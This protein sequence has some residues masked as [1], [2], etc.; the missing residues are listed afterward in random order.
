MKLIYPIE[1][2]AKLDEHV[3]GQD[4]AKTAL[5]VA[6]FEHQMRCQ[7]PE[8]Q[9]DKSNVFLIGPS[10]SGKTILVETLAGIADVPFSINSAT[11]LTESGYVGEDVENVLRRLLEASEYDL[12][13]AEKGIVFID[14]FDKIARK[15]KENM[16][17]TRDVG[18]EG[19][20]QALLRII[21]GCDIEVPLTSG[22]RHP[23][24]ECIVMNTENI[25][26]ILSGAFEGIKCQEESITPQDLIAYGM[27]HELVGR[28]PVI[29]EVEPLDIEELKRI[30]TE[31]KNAIIPQ[32]KALFRQMDIDLEFSDGAV[33][34]IA[35]SA[36]FRG[37]GARGL[38]SFI[39]KLLQ[40][41][42]FS[43]EKY[44]GETITIEALDVLGIAA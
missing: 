37:T 22:R 42:I 7:F 35:A 8:L 39:E 10:G 20:Q 19:V 26:F 24:E 21:E 13:K 31:P 28:V 38:R 11:S 32:F 5:S 27:L 29:A 33:S 34:E 41:Y 17:I 4:E 15:S 1:I 40:S 43:V 16:S 25:L 6:I 14:E 44:Q 30:M 18:G 3:V 9:M 23:Y 12:E 2:K 36:Y